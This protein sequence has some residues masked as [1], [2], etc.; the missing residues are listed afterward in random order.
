MNT[1]NTVS[2]DAITRF[3][4]NSAGMDGGAIFTIANNTITS[5]NGSTTVFSRN[6][7]KGRGGALTMNAG[8]IVTFNGTTTFTS[9]YA[10]RQGGAIAVSA[11]ALV[12]GPSAITFVNNS[13]L[14][15]SAMYL[16]SSSTSSI[17]LLA[18]H[19]N[20]IMFKNNVCRGGKQGGTVFAVKD[21]QTTTD[22]FGPQI[23]HYNQRV[24]FVNNVAAV[25]KGVATQTTIVRSTSNHTTIIVTDYNL[26]LRPSLVFNLIDAFNNINTTD[27]ATTVSN[28]NSALSYLALL[29]Y[30][31]TI[32][33]P[34]PH[35]YPAVT[36]PCC[37][38]CYYYI[39]SL[40]AC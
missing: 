18:S 11:S 37:H 5:L 35:P 20:G 26:F 1:V 31:S 19:T 25:G 10:Q 15:G 33:F 8:S 12:L 13:A 24:V 34:A 4:Q 14:S 23:P 39:R 9:N 32:S 7:C 2:I 28:H 27:F 16:M 36:N 22:L 3:F 6:S 29:Y 17:T 30:T 38:C 21:L 40:R